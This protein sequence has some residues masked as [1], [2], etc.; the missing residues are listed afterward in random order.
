MF[1]PERI[2]VA[3]LDGR[4][5][6]ADKVVPLALARLEKMI[7]SR[8]GG[9]LDQD[10]PIVKVKVLETELPEELQDPKNFPLDPEFYQGLVDRIVDTLGEVIRTEEPKAE[11]GDVIHLQAYH[12]G[13]TPGELPANCDFFVGRMRCLKCS[14]ISRGDTATNCET[15]LRESPDGRAIRVGDN[16]G[17]LVDTAR[18][19]YYASQNLGN[20]GPLHVLEGWECPCCRSVNWAEVVIRD[21]VVESIWSVK[22]TSDVLQRAHLFSSECVEIAAELTGR[23]PWTLLDEDI[24]AILAEHL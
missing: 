22:L 13:E 3:Y 12:T 18:P 10:N 19:D 17:V 16:I 9:V 15:F 6:S 20:D 14:Y 8:L 24:L 4:N 2:L 11:E 21:E 5:S 1:E 23:P 7:E